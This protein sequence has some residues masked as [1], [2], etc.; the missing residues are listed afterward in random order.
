LTP[1]LSDRADGTAKGR[2]EIFSENLAHWCASEALDS[3]VDP[4]VGD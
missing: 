1:H 2:I 4:G 3:V